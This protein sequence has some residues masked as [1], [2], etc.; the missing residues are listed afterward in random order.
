MGQLDQKL[1]HYV[2]DRLAQA[3]SG[4]A[5]A[6]YDLGLLY[7]TGQGVARDYV[8]AHKW[9]NLASICGVR[10]AQVDRCELARDMEKNDIA[11]AQRQA[12]EWLDSHSPEA[13]PA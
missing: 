10:R 5:E 8:Q 2:T 9:F 11:E 12:R 7:S 1:D 13:P 6:L 3:E 4:R